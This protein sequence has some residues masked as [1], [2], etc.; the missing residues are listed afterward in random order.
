MSNHLDRDPFTNR[1]VFEEYARG[2]AYLDQKEEQQKRQGRL[3]RFADAKFGES[4]RALEPGNPI[5]G[6]GF[7]PRGYFEDAVP[8]DKAENFLKYLLYKN[9][10]SIRS[11][12]AQAGI[13]IKPNFGPNQSFLSLN[14][15]TTKKGHYFPLIL[16]NHSPANTYELPEEPFDLFRFYLPN[17]P[18]K[19]SDLLSL[20]QEMN[21]RPLGICNKNA[22][23]DYRLSDLQKLPSDHQLLDPTYQFSVDSLI[24]EVE[25]RA[26]YDLSPACIPIND[27]L[28]PPHTQRGSLHRTLR[29]SWD[30]TNFPSYYD[31]PTVEIGATQKLIMPQEYAGIIDTNN[32]PDIWPGWVK[33]IASPLIDPG[34]GKSEAD[35]MPVIVERN[36]YRDVS[37][38]NN[39]VFLS[40]HKVAI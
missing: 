1:E 11:K 9:C 40:L 32:S 26:S 2:W 8:D 14:A 4:L 3:V 38:D 24:M 28:K 17:E 12:I 21:L 39:S 30:G 29:L 20:V 7:I 5:E 31:T 18:V 33:H 10:I 27:F 34:F 16:L 13:N 23:K 25:Q 35:G 36:L 37:N 22:P 6:W 15:C 19:G